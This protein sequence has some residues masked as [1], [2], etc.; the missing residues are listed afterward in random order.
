MLK[1]SFSTICSKSLKKKF[2][3]IYEKTAF[4]RFWKGGILS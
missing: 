3:A 1:S 4:K 2:G